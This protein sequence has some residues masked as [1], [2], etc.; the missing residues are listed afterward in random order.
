MTHN[1]H[2]FYATLG[3]AYMQQTFFLPVRVGW[4]W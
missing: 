1:W 3:V 2:S 4:R